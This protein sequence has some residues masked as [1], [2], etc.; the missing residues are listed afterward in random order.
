M[1]LQLEALP[2]SRLTVIGLCPM[3]DFCKML[4]PLISGYKISPINFVIKIKFQFYDNHIFINYRK[5]HA[6]N[7]HVI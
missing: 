3:A 6:W 4:A 5:I 2:V 1:S 7:T